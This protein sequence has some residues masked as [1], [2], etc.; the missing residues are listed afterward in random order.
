MNSKVKVAGTTSAYGDLP[1]ITPAS[2]TT[3][4]TGLTVTD[5]TWL[6]VNKDNIE[7]L[8]LTKCQPIKM[9]GVLSIS[10]NYYN[11]SIDGTTVQGS[12]SYP[13]ESLGLANLAV[14]II[15]FYFYFAVCN[16]SK[17]LNIIAVSVKDEG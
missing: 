5:P 12:I 14:H 16:N 10:G 2:V 9:T 7:N 6:E 1:Q 17:F 13:L 4:E 3:L 15:T 8:D 11:I